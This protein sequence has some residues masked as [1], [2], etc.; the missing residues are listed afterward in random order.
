MSTHA[1]E[2]M[3]VQ[4][5]HYDREDAVGHLHE[6]LASMINSIPAGVR[7]PVTVAELLTLTGCDEAADAAGTVFMPNNDLPF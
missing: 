3:L 6:Q 7:L 5:D 2:R 1:L 4:V